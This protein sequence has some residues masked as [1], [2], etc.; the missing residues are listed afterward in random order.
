MKDRKSGWF[1]LRSRIILFCMLLASGILLDGCE[2]KKEPESQAH[3][4]ALPV[5]IFLDD[6]E[7]NIGSLS[8]ESEDNLRVYITLDGM[9]LIDLPFGEAHTIRILQI[10]G[11]ENI[12]KVTGNAVYMEDSNCRNHDCMLMGEI[13]RDNLEIRVMG[14][15]I[16]CLPH[17]LGVEVRNIRDR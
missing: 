9:V 4:Q 14:G 7:W 2:K 15:F 13:T 10:N 6:A 11:D 3:S 8:P 5:Q 1:F 12:V 17:R 16:I